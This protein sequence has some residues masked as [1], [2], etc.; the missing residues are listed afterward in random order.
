MEKV[1]IIGGGY[2]GLYALR[3]L[4]KDKNIKITLID[5]NTFHNLQPEVYDLIAN[6]V[7]ISDV[8][9]DLAT[10]CVGLDHSYL[11]YKNL[12]VT[13]IDYEKKVIN[14][15]E[16]EIIEF[17]YLIIAAGTRTSFPPSISGINTAHDIK[18]L[19]W[20]IYFKQCFE[21][22]LFK[23]IQ[24][25]VKESNNIEIIVVGAG[26]SGVEIAAEM[27]Y[28]S[29]KFFKRGN[30][31]CDNL[32]ISLIS[33]ADTILPGLDS[34]LIRLSQK[35]LKSLG[36]EVITNTKLKKCEDEI[37]YFTNGTKKEYSFL[38]FAGGI[39]ASKLT[40]ELDVQKNKKGQ[41]IVNEYMQT[42]KYENIFA[43]GDV[44]E[45]KNEKDEIM[46]PNVTIAKIS[47]IN[48][49]QN[50]LNIINNKQLI[51]SK[52]K[53]DGILIALG[54]KYA[55]GSIYGLFHVKGRIAY[56]IKKFVFYSYKKPL[57]RLISEGY[58]KLRN[59]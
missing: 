14:T 11:E 46:P 59:I 25:E 18:K 37:A 3:E 20:A 7:E 21:N 42:S 4:V 17:D 47:G 32:K 27:A 19:N 22:R 38:I 48:A 29:K 33:S 56:E 49:G 1:V 34:E 28:N 30:F 16:E 55:V 8:A 40:E 36:I 5:S 54:G 12:K 57:L 2:A 53:L 31:T 39:E 43:I 58:N 9:V 52:P 35:R 50:I 45:I 24:Y 41:I 6:K 26:L 44:A 51:K 15:A 13:Q 23:K 10:L